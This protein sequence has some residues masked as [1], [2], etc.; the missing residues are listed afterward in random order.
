[1]KLTA[2]FVAS[3]KYFFLL[4][5]TTSFIARSLIKYARKH[6]ISIETEAK[7]TQTTN[8]FVVDPS[9]QNLN[10]KPSP[11]VQIHLIFT[12][13]SRE[14]LNKGN[15]FLAKY[16]EQTQLIYLD[17]DTDNEEIV[18]KIIWFAL[19]KGE[20]P[21]IFIRTLKSTPEETLKPIVKPNQFKLKKRHILVVFL[22]SQL[23]FLLPLSISIIF[24]SQAGHLF[25][26]G[27]IIESKNAVAHAK[28]VS[29]GTHILYFIARPLLG[30]LYIAPTVENIINAVDIST[31][32]L[33]LTLSS[34]E[35]A[36]QL[37]ALI[38]HKEPVPSDKGEISL[39]LKI[40]KDKS[41][42][43]EKNSKVLSG[44]LSLI[45]IIKQTDIE[46]LEKYSKI[47][48]QVRDFIDIAPQFLGRDGEKK[49]LIFFYNNMELRPGGGFLGSYATL[50]LKNYHLQSLELF[51][52]YDIDGQL[53][54][55]IEPPGPL[56]IYLNQPHWFTRDSNFSPDFTVNSEVAKSFLEKIFGQ[57]Q[58]V[59]GYIGITTSALSNILSS[60]PPVYLSDYNETITQENFF[61]KTQTEV[62]S[63]HFEGSKK[64]KNY[65]GSIMQALILSSD[66][67]SLTKLGEGL[68]K[69]LAEKHIVFNIA[70]NRVNIFFKRNGWG[71][72]LTVP[73]C[74][75]GKNCLVNYVSAIDANLGVNK[76][77]YY[78][79]RQ[80]NI[81]SN[82][83]SKKILKSQVLIIFT[84]QSP[85]GSFP[86]G[87]YKNYFRLYIPASG[88][89][90]GVDVNDT[91]SSTFS[92]SSDKGFK[93]IS[94]FITV[95]PQQSTTIKITYNLDVP[96][97]VDS[98]QLVVQKQIGSINNEMSLAFDTNKSSYHLRPQNFAPVEKD[99]Q[100]LYNTVLL[101]D[102]VFFIKL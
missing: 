75:E 78:V 37:V 76:S 39:R 46:K 87:E 56:R 30:F 74:L 17:S 27:K 21:T 67:A 70:D 34:T 86:G 60:F 25:K 28:Q 26:T 64:K 63:N 14:S 7:E 57:R 84:N 99:R 82:F 33:E 51:D 18:E 92:V 3:K 81:T 20:E 47:L 101:S 71:G 13:H 54:G 40:L 16:R 66:K 79:T 98:Y 58:D 2:D 44:K 89:N 8:I 41:L 48:S 4:G 15:S 77:N 9:T 49:Y 95:P 6:N 69:S 22:L 53:K 102:R 52:I 50:T 29:F 43:L 83:V 23:L 91:P 85:N 94:Q 1:M 80:F 32:T 45:P 88:Q 73:Q 55:H 97:F 93:T 72:N 100:L 68:G 62:E 5:H 12:N 38:T 19:S 31:T 10:I 96:D 90:V 24:L 11:N 42:Q 59:S 65:L 36:H 61:L 35:N